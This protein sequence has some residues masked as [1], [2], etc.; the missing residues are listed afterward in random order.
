MAKDKYVEMRIETDCFGPFVFRVGVDIASLDSLLVRID[1]AQ[2]RFKTSPLSQVANRFEKEVLVS[3]IFST[4]SI[5][6]GTLSVEETEQ[7]LGLSLTQV[8]DI[9]QHRAINLKNAYELAQQA[10][11]QSGWQLN[12]DFIRQIHI[13][14]TDQLPHEFNRP[15]ILRDNPK[16]IVTRVGNQEHGG[17]YKPPQ[18]GK[19]IEQLLSG[20]IEWHQQLVDQGVSVL[21]RAPLVHLYYELI[22]PFWDGNG[23]VG[24]ILEATLLQAEGYKYASFG[25]ARYYLEHIH[26][27]FTL[28]NISR[29]DADKKIEAPNT[30]F[31]SFFLQ[32]ILASIN[33]LHD[34]VN[35]LI[36]LKLFENEVKRLYD[37]KKINA[38]QYA[39]A[40]QIMVNGKS[41][42][43]TALRNAPWYQV[44]Y[45][46]LSDKTKQRDLKGLRELGVVV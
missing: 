2:K 22:H 35:T 21:I 7:A 1:D 27:Y 42:S 40:S 5:E 20:L 39:I 32:G 14:V 33:N 43:L 36:A 23:R 12:M 15:G 38:R 26:T 34:R 41:A 18:Y 29:K 25:Q 16:G 37:E 17:V 45:L 6:G 31:V 13:A 44:L 24:R 3:S 30:R 28:F 10:A 9:E 19:D 46:R 4:N 11:V 8:Q